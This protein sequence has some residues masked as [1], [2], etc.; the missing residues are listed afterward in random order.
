MQSYRENTK[1]LCK[2]KQEAKEKL[3][4]EAAMLTKLARSRYQ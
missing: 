3:E 1:L 2:K 4:D